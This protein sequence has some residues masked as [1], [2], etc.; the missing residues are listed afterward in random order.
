MSEP[1][2][3]ERK[4]GAVTAGE[5]ESEAQTIAPYETALN[6]ASDKLTPQVFIFL[7]AYAILLIGL[8]VY[9]LSLGLGAWRPFKP[10]FR[11]RSYTFVFFRLPA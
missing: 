7:P 11:E 9:G 2:N 8:T 3:P 6:K 4:N 10:G 1:W 5:G